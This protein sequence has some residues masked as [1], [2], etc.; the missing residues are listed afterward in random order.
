[1]SNL[2][3]AEVVPT[4][5]EARAG[6]FAK[7]RI[8]RRLAGLSV[9]IALAGAA[10]F[11]RTAPAQTKA[12]EYRVKAAFLYH[13]AQLVEWPDIPQG[14]DNNLLLCTLGDDPFQGELESTIAGKQ[15]GARILRVR[16]LN[17]VQA[18]HGCNLVFIGKNQDKHLP[19]ILAGLR[20]TPVL[21]VGEA[22]DFLGSG[23]IIR[24]CLEGNK[25]RFEINRE[26]A[27]SA[28]LRISA[29]LLLLARNIAGSSG[30]Q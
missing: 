6:C 23:G 15:V 2:A 30:G 20:N 16:H 4:D 24:F 7:S 13:F 14:G 21:T 11:P 26:A 22:D 12:D 19:A 8:R 28:K 18:T 17:D 25:V 1:M 9:L 3:K 5:A 10:L 29:K 27:E